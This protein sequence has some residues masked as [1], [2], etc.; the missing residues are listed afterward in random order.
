MTR[1]GP[2]RVDEV[3]TDGAALTTSGMAASRLPLGVS[4]ARPKSW[5]PLVVSAVPASTIMIWL[6]IVSSPAG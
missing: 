6:L 3:G 4:R 2:V 5:P 1:S